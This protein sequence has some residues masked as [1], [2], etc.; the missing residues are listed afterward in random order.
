MVGGPGVAVRVSL[1]D[2]AGRLRVQASSGT[3]RD[4]GR[5][6]STRRRQAFAEA[7]P[8]KVVM[9]SPPER[10]LHILP[11]VSEGEALG[12][13]EIVGPA[14][15]LAEREDALAAAIQQ[16]ALL[17]RAAAD[18]AEVDRAMRGMASLFELTSQL[19]T[20]DTPLDALR[21]GVDLC[22][23]EL[24]VPAA[25]IRPDRGGQGWYLA[26]AAGMGAR[27]RSGFRST[28]HRLMVHGRPEDVHASV[29]EAFADAVGWDR[30]EVVPTGEALML[31][32]GRSN[33]RQGFLSA[34]GSLVGEA[35]SHS[36][37]LRTARSRIE[38]LDLGIAWTA[39]ELR[40]PLIGASAA[41]DHV[42]ESVEGAGGNE[43]LLRTRGE[44][45]R[46]TELVGPLLRWSAGSELLDRR[47]VELGDIVREAVDACVLE[48]PDHRIVI[49]VTA[50]VPVRAD[51]R[52][53]SGAIANV[54]RNALAYSPTSAPVRI[55]VERDGERASVCISD[56]GPGIAPEERD[57]IFDPFARGAAGDGMRSGNGLGLFIARR[58]ALAHGGALRLLPSRRGATFCFELAVASERRHASAS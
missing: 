18:R 33:G 54:L 8:V 15:R 50:S 40:G 19:M 31:V 48:H 21:L 34:V 23:E 56:R 6:R 12:V 35:M 3:H 17:L 2:R 10:E 30:A 7:T 14:G 37:D 45:E 53:L 27:R 46:L 32:A 41:L 25:G 4:E 57:L 39:H 26:A 47:R 51:A 38:G 11:L 36:G 44:L 22:S 1:P 52:Q 55:V 5:L 29:A 16:S 9:G 42:L 13:V 49:D 24:R 43:L 58:V 20:A 28:A